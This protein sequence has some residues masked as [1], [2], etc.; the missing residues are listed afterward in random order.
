MNMNKYM[1]DLLMPH[2]KD[3]ALLVGQIL[4]ELSGQGEVCLL[5]VYVFSR[6]REGS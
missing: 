2:T 3:I 5:S 1:S 4:D 6:A